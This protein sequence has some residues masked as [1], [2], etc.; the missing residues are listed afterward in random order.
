[1][2]FIIMMNISMLFPFLKHPISMGM[3][4]LMQTL[5]IS[6]VSGMMINSFWFSYL[7]FLMILGG[8]LVL[9][10]YM[11]SVASNEMIKFSNKMYLTIAM[12]AIM[13]PLM[14]YL[15]KFLMMKI[16]MEKLHI[17]INNNQMLSMNK[18]MNNM[19]MIMIMIMFL[20]MTMIA[21]IYLIKIFKGP[22]RK[23]N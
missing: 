22:L 18:M 8:L 1:M 15:D 5:Y 6:M 2:M 12:M 9:F 13:S 14:F 19:I 23:F 20:L 21:I 17:L 7:F 11:A 10:I 16:N 4:L 3:L